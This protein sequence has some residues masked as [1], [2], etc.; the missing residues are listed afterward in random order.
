LAVIEPEV[1]HLEEY[2]E[3]YCRWKELLEKM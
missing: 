1:G 2:A 3:A